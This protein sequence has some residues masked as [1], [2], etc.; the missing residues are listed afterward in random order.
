MAVSSKYASGRLALG[1][2]DRCGFQYRLHELKEEFYDLRPNG[3]RVCP[4]CMDQDHPQLQLGEIIISDPQALYDPRPDVNTPA[5]TGYFG[6]RPIGHP[7]T[8]KLESGLGTLT[9]VVT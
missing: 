6:W 9:V 4:T 8:G 3:L 2:C 1:L 5:S 7:I